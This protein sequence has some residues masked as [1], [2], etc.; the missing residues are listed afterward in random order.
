MSN[1]K[2]SPSDAARA[3]ATRMRG[4]AVIVATIDNARAARNAAIKR[5]RD[6]AGHYLDSAGAREIMYLMHNRHGVCG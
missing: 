5:E 2:L 6:E 3:R 1:T 4:N